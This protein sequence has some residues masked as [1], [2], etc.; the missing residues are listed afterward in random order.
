MRA[1]KP[2]SRGTRGARTLLCACAAVLL[3]GAFPARATAGDPIVETLPATGI[4]RMSS[5][6]NG[7][8]TTNDWGVWWFQW[9]TTTQYDQETNHFGFEPGEHTVQ[10]RLMYLQPDTEYHYRLVVVIP[11]FPPQVYY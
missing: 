6:I 1:A 4:W 8:F 11:A 9:G 3:V 2:V 5:Y 10:L 7:H